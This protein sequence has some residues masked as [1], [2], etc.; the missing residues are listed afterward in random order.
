MRPIHSLWV[1]VFL[2]TAVGPA[3][4][5]P[6]TP[7]PFYAITNVQVVTGNGPTLEGATVLVA[8]GLIEAVGAGV[9]VPGDAWEIDGQGMM[10]FPGLID[11]LTTVGQK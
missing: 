2:A 11:A 5:E 8:N 3:Q 7:P 4:A 6:P 1:A 10:L 9:T